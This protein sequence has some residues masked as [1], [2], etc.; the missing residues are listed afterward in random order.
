MLVSSISTISTIPTV[1][2]KAMAITIAMSIAIAIAMSIAIAIAMAIAIAV[3]ADASVAI[4]IGKLVSVVEPVPVPV[5]VPVGEG[6]VGV[7]VRESVSLGNSHNAQTPE[8]IYKGDKD[9]R[10]EVNLCF[11]LERNCP[12]PLTGHIS[13]ICPRAQQRPVSQ[14]HCILL[15]PC[16]RALG[17][18]HRQSPQKPP[19]AYFITAPVRMLG[20]KPRL[21]GCGCEGHCSQGWPHA[22]PMVAQQRVLVQTIPLSW[23]WHIWLFTWTPPGSISSHRS[24][25]P[26]PESHPST[27]TAILSTLIQSPRCPNS[28]APNSSCASERR[29]RHSPLGEGV[30]LLPRIYVLWLWT[31]SDRRT[32][33]GTQRRTG[34]S[35]AGT[36]ADERAKDLQTHSGIALPCCSWN[37]LEEEKGVG[38]I[39]SEVSHQQASIK[40]IQAQLKGEVENHKRMDTETRRRA[41]LSRTAGQ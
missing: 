25:D 37:D 23:P 39:P 13:G 8:L 32:F 16:D 18:K 28:T 26:G 14:Q 38:R 22:R 33:L 27:S 11:L 4:S 24:W 41:H 1:V 10:E 36:E 5:P 17:S 30:K 7:G 21:Q 35:R 29:R 15:P 20:M 6:S 31:G 3:A 34:L 9:P 2:S 12:D 19:L 40:S